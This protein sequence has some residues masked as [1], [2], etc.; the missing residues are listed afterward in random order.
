MHMWAIIFNRKM[1]LD[2]LPL[3]E[4]VSKKTEEKNTTSLFSQ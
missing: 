3:L 4:G 2:K 1:N